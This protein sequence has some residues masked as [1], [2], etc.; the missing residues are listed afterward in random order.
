MVRIPS[1]GEAHAHGEMETHHCMA[2]TTKR[3][4]DTQGE[5][6]TRSGQQDHRPGREQ[7]VR[8]T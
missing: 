7:G 6:S 3:D 2:V 5:L 1:P 4:P 8:T